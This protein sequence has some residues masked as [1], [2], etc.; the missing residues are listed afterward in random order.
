MLGARTPRLARIGAWFA[1]L[2]ILM[3][4]RYGLDA[5]V[6]WLGPGAGT[7]TV[8][9]VCDALLL[10]VPLVG[11]IILLLLARRDWSELREEPLTV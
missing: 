2:L 7:G 8:R 10:I 3:Y 5:L 1:P 9:Q 11:A 4:A 6:R